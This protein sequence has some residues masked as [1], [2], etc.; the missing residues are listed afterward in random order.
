MIKKFIYGSFVYEYKL[1]REERKTLILTVKPDLQLLVKSPIE[2][3]DIRI[4]QFLKRKWFWL[5]KQINFFKK[6][7]R[8]VYEREYVSGE[9]FLYLGRQYQLIIKKSVEN[10]VILSHGKINL[11]TTMFVSDKAYNKLL[12]DRWYHKATKNVFA[13][14]FE[15]M[16]KLFDY[17]KMPALGIRKMDKRWGSFL[18]DDKIFLNPRLI[19]ASKECIDYVIC[20]E[21]CHMEYKDHDAKFYKLLEKK[22]HGWDKIKDKLESYLG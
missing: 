5:Q 11:F 10:K 2:A 3:D 13:E 20:H 12:I 19:G 6:F 22:R 15:E 8:K 9:S 14:R 1:A 21:L 16:K 17:K 7:K 18:N 4:E